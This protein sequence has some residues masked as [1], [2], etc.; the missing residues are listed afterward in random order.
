MA[1]P[2]GRGTGVRSTKPQRRRVVVL[3]VFGPFPTRKN[4]EDERKR[5]GI[6]LPGSNCKRIAELLDELKK[7]ATLG[8]AVRPL[9]EQLS[10][11]KTYRTE[12]G[13]KHPKWDDW[14][15][16]EVEDRA[17]HAADQLVQIQKAPRDWAQ[18]VQE[19]ENRLPA[20][21]QVAQAPEPIEVSFPKVEKLVAEIVAAVG[22]IKT[23]LVQVAEA[24]PKLA[25]AAQSCQLMSVQAKKLI[26][27]L[28]ERRKNRPGI[29]FDP[30]PVH[31]FRLLSQEFADQV[32]KLMP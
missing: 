16:R 11:V 18:P 3:S 29:P 22:F 6:L 14:L 32:K 1:P 20:L 31:R 17:K 23:R 21:A 7:C 24:D 26:N 27:D 4:Y 19:I 12:I 2:G 5:R 10:T 25:P 30:A 13:R 9:N 28:L 15:G 8:D